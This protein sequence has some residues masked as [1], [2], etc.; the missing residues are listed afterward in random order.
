M[1]KDKKLNELLMQ[2]AMEETDAD[3]TA[4]VMDKI[5]ALQT[6][7]HSI[8]SLLHNGLVNILVGVFV[9]VCITLLVVSIVMQ[10]FGSGIN[11][12]ILPSSYTTQL[13]YF[14]IAF[15]VVMLTNQWLKKR[16]G[17]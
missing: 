17:T 15:W 11:I 16:M 14:F 7:K 3:F 2:H 10:P 6:S 4:G 8:T 13:I 9:F 5:A 1:Q 12:N